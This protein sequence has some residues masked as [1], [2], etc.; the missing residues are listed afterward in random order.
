MKR[1]EYY[2]NECL[3]ISTKGAGF[4]SPNPLVGC[5]ILK[6]NKIIGK[7][8]HHYFGG[9]HA[10]VNAIKDAKSRGYDPKGATLYV[11]LEPCSHYGKTPPCTD[12]IIRENISTVIIGTK[13][14]NS[15]VN[16]KG[17]SI[18]K[19]H[20]IKVILNVLAEKCR[21][22][23]KFYI[24]FI[25]E[26]RP[27]I[28][29][30][31]AQSID[32]KIKPE[33]MKSIWLTCNESIKYVHKLRRIYDAVLV[34]KNT[35]INDNPLLTVRCVKGRNPKRFI[36]DRKLEIDKSHKIFRYGDTEN[37]FLITSLKNRDVKYFSKLIFLREYH[38][39][40]RINDILKSLY[41]LKISSLL[42]EG[43]ADVFSQFSQNNLFDEIH[44]L[45][46][47]IVIG[48]GLSSF[49]DVVF[50]NKKCKNKLILFQI[51]K[52]KEDI[53]L[54]YKNKKYVYGNSN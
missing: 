45:I 24:R 19:K 31:I 54:I 13:D 18:L 5:Y 41:E 17:I 7:G 3:K 38:N 22:H 29:L 42:V 46:S 53:L 39:R 16:G 27:Y 33:G 44:L 8:Y 4:V 52:F 23:N 12:A 49:D 14:P 51:N 48:K 47:P 11:N 26:N 40:F 25:S 30:K 28:T 6:N 35:I 34:G 50:D 36:L 32:G 20:G 10:E 2:I 9:N 21:E 37:T 15:E 43:G 1:D